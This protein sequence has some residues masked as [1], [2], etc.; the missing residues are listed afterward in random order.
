MLSLETI[1]SWG[2]NMDANQI[3]SESNVGLNVAK[4]A[5]NKCTA[6]KDILK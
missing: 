6:F 5:E 4:P 1:I 3:T 2:G